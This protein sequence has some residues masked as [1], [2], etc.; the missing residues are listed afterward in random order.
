MHDEL[1]GQII[2]AA[3]KVHSRLGPG[4]FERVYEECLALE[5]R[6][7]GLLVERQ[8]LAPVRYDGV[9]IELGYRMDLVVN[10]TVI[11]ELKTVS[12]LHA[13]HEAQLTAYVKMS[14]KPV[15][16]LI[17]FNVKSLK[18]SCSPFGRTQTYTDLTVPPSAPA[19][20]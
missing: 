17:N 6:R 4:F 3:M 8:V 2:G 18:D 16:L 11:I 12:H 19:R 5:L 1:T 20:T 13:V 15:G 14:E 7:T 10:Q 9:L